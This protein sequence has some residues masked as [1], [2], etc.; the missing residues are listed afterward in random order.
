MS[1]PRLRTFDGSRVPWARRSA[2]VGP[3]NQLADQE[4]DSIVPPTVEQSDE[5]A[6]LELDEQ[7]GLDLEPACVSGPGPQVLSMTDR[8]KT[9]PWPGRR[10]P[11]HACPR[12]DPMFVNAPKGEAR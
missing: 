6:M 5:V 10:R 11:S 9:G 8:S 3:S 7:P 2:S 1:R 4:W 12:P